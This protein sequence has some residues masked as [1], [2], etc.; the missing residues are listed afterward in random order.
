MLVL[1]PP[2]GKLVS[3]YECSK[4]LLC[5]HVYGKYLVSSAEGKSHFVLKYGQLE[6]K[7]EERVGQV[8]RFQC[9]HYFS[10]S[11][12]YKNTAYYKSTL[13]SVLHLKPGFNNIVYKESI[14]GP[15][16]IYSIHLNDRTPF[17]RLHK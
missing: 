4:E 10:G 5:F 1:C 14:M 3:A 2:V 6:G 16:Q 17:L 12:C 9:I 8:L 15:S 13:N 7:R 11:P